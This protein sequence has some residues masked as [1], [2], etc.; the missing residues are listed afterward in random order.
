MGK[1]WVIGNTT[2][3]NPARLKDGLKVFYE[4]P[5]YG[6]LIVNDRQNRLMDELSRAGIVETSGSNSD[7]GGRKWLAAF[8][9]LGFITYK[10]KRNIKDGE[11]DP[12]ILE[13]IYNEQKQ[14]IIDLTGKPHEITPNGLRLIRAESIREQQEC[15][16]RAILAYQIP[17]I[18][19]N[20][21]NQQESF[22][23]LKFCIQVLKKLGESDNP[24]GLSIPEVAI[25]QSY[26]KH[27]DLD[28]AVQEILEYRSRREQQTGL[29]AKRRIDND[30]YNQK[31][32]EA[33]ISAE[34]VKDYADTNF[35]YLRFTGLFSLKGKRIVLNNDKLPLIESI[36]DFPLIDNSNP[37]AYLLRL[38][39]GAELPTDDEIGARR[40]ISH[41]TNLIIQY[42]VDKEVLPKIPSNPTIAELTQIRIRL[43]E[44]YKE[45]QEQKFA[46][47]Q[48]D[49]I[50]E[51][52]AYLKLLDNQS[53]S[54]EFEINLR[55]DEKPAYLEWAVWRS[56]LAINH[57]LNEPYEARRFEVD[58]DFLPVG[59][60][61]PNG[62]DMIFEFDDYILIVEVTL[63]T[64][65]RQEAAEGEPVRR[66]VAKEKERIGQ[67]T[68]K[69][70]YGLF[71]ARSI[72]NNT[73]ETFRI[74]IWYNGDEPD[75]LNIVPITL[76][77]FITIMEYFADKK[78]NPNDFRRLLDSCLIPRNAH[79]PVWKQEISRSIQKFINSNI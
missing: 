6:S 13:V 40:D 37:K 9:Q 70:V 59:F 25:V 1:P 4:S 21:W 44:I 62:P 2:I 55:N 66:H 17:S 78:F 19:E 36:L 26:T 53:I 43:E 52:I 27:S 30:L 33:G 54:E 68:Q 28:K 24:K 46:K 48:K 5:L 32:A 34:S 57:L 11:I 3:R 64:S 10:F 56:F 16:L 41:Y 39:N 63:T 12:T 42:G 71:I 50:K 38:W 49:Q 23:P 22:S 61:P 18:I 45:L 7:W 65:S 14:K 8:S 51:I 79:A 69:P 29:M 35:R 58:N 67:Q 75:F 20:R 74:G 77:D 72:D 60:A 47:R 31:G 15:M 73:A 76:K